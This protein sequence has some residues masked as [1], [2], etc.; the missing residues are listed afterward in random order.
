MHEKALDEYTH[1]Q[2]MFVVDAASFSSSR[3]QLL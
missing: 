3:K 2:A 1:E